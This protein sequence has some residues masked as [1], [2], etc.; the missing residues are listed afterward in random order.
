[1]S[2]PQTTSTFRLN[3]GQFKANVLLGGPQRHTLIYGGSRSGKTSLI[4]RATLIRGGRSPKSR[5]VILRQ[6]ANA[7]RASISLDTL[8][9]V[10]RLC[11]PDLKLEEHRQDGFFMMPNKSEI[12]VGGLDDKHV[13]K[14]L[15][16]E[17]ATICF[18]ECSQF[19]YSSVLV[20]LTR[21]AQVTHEIRQ[22]AIYDLNPV[23]KLHW[24]HQLFLEHRDPVSRRPLTNPDDYKFI[25]LNPVDNRANLTKEYLDSLREMPPRQRKR[26]FDGEFV[27]ELEEALWSYEL[28]EQTRV[29]E[30][31]LDDLKRV[32][33]AV[34]P[35][36]AAGKDDV[37]ADEIGIVVVG[38]GHD[39]EGYVLA[40]RS[41]KDGPAA[42]GRAAVRAYH[43]FDADC[44]IAERNFGGEMVR[45]TIQSSDHNVPVRVIT[46]SRGKAVRAEPVSALYA[47]KKVHHVTKVLAPGR[48]FSEQRFTV[49]ED[50]M[51]SFT[52]SGYFGERSPDH[53]DALVW[54]L[55]ELM[56]E[57]TKGWGLIEYY[58]QES[59]KSGVRTVQPEFGYSIQ[60]ASRIATIKMRAPVGTSTVY[61]MS[62]TLYQVGSENVVVVSSEDAAPLRGQG[63]EE[64]S[65]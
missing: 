48:E 12:W 43:D 44:V 30:I 18:N 45:Y 2:S 55:T 41:V 3:P 38:V 57:Q 34:D 59:E 23:G 7:A 53:A 52:T 32:V 24:S 46:A 27:D 37:G 25:R 60:P 26:F 11:F 40:D 14:F 47:N 36:G 16:K 54:G 62:G 61:G 33:V 10:A 49:L 1:M 58:R 4:V 39:G 63:F 35:S 29:A 64:I 20:G 17:Y 5:H 19:L 15:G 6:Q 42:W 65:S 28:I 51:C 22:R 50:Q 9:K 31:A 8:P 56:L 21:L 13:E